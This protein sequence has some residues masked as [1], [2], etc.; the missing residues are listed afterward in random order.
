MGQQAAQRLERLRRYRATHPGAPTLANELKRQT[1][2]LAK[3]YRSLHGLGEAWG[4]VV[5]AEIGKTVQIVSLRRGVLTV[6]CGDSA[7]GY[8]LDRWLRDGG[9]EALRRHSPAALTRVKVLS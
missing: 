3:Q 2:T 4:R 7:A 1:A 6:R 5:P 8:L 9:L